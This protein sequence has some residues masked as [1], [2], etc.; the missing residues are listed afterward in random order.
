MCKM[1][2]ELPTVLCKL[3]RNSRSKMEKAAA[4]GHSMTAY[5]CALETLARR[6]TFVVCWVSFQ[7]DHE[8]EG[9]GPQ[10]DLGIQKALSYRKTTGR[11]LLAVP[12]SWLNNRAKVWEFWLRASCHST[13]KP[14]D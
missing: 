5:C 8:Q 9:G 10:K 13:P 1:S 14:R 12:P 2:L 11:A 4:P 6:L 7:L 3:A